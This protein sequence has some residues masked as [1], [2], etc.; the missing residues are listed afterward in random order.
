MSVI[1]QFGKL[2]EDKNFNNC[3]LNMIT[4]LV[5]LRKR[6]ERAERKESLLYVAARVIPLSFGVHSFSVAM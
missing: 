4:L 3:E 5:K 1:R 2:L 6:Y